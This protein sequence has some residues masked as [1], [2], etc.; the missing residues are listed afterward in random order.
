MKKDIGIGILDLYTEEDLKKTLIKIIR[1]GYKPIVF[2]LGEPL[3]FK[4]KADK[5]VFSK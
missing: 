3:K 4:Y 1:N 2:K 5:I